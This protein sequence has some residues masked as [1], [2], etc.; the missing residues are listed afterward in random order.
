MKLLCLAD[1]HG[2]AAELRAALA[3]AAS[4]DAVILAGDITQLGGAGETDALIGQLLQGGTRV[5]AVAGNMDRAGV[6]D[7]LG[8][9][10]VDIH[11]RGVVIDGVGFFGLGGGT[12]SPFA[13]PWEVEDAEAD[14]LLAAGWEEVADA[15]WK[16]LVSH[17]PPRDTDLDRVREGVHGGSLPVRSFLL[18]HRVDLCLCGHI[19]EGGGREISL[20]GCRCANV[21]PLKGG[22]FALV[23]I[24][25]E[26][27]T[28]TW[29][30]T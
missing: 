18:A 3:E 20:G 2:K 13:T 17:A 21:G 5:L 19:H 15:R 25:N 1:I 9:K 16:V 14:A 24:D 26:E 4:V 10:Q 23:S 30:N 11:G 8:K 12:R 7:Y 22:R 6:R 29:R 27:T 28:V